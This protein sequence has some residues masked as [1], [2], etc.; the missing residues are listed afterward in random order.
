MIISGVVD[1]ADRAVRFDQGVLSLHNVSIAR[2]PLAFLVPC[3]AVSDAI[4]ELVPW[5]RLEFQKYA[6]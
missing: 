2:F 5:V 6:L 3:V 4:I 1:C